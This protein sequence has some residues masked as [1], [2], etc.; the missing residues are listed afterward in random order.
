MDPYET[1]EELGLVGALGAKKPIS[2]QP[3]AYVHAS[4]HHPKVQT[5][6]ERAISMQP[7]LFPQKSGQIKSQAS[8]IAVLYASD[9]D[10]VDS[11][12]KGGH[13]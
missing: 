3:S 5:L 8:D 12:G 13:L 11:D 2:R 6:S 4:D 10:C 1:E 7:N 9:D